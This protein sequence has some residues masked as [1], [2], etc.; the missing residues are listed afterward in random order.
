MPK[1]NPYK[2]RKESLLPVI[3]VYLNTPQEIWVFNVD[4]NTN[5]DPEN[6]IQVRVECPKCHWSGVERII[7]NGHNQH[8]VEIEHQKMIKEAY[9][10]RCPYCH[11][12]W[13]L[14]ATRPADY[15]TLALDAGDD[16]NAGI[17]EV[18]NEIKD[19]MKENK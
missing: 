1:L 10:C 3:D 15:K 16:L 11:N 12:A 14:D 5:T 7:G 6:W 13:E 19:S 4:L 9:F 17:Q 8:I 2:N 18:D